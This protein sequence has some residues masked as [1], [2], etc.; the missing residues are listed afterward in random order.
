MEEVRLGR[1]RAISGRADATWAPT[2]KTYAM[3]IMRR[4]TPSSEQSRDS[5]IKWIQTLSRRSEAKAANKELWVNVV[6]KL[7]QRGRVNWRR[8]FFTASPKDGQSQLRAHDSAS[9]EI[10]ERA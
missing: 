8:H 4:S 5:N 9:I 3:C 2:S 6:E 1:L 10:I 7:V